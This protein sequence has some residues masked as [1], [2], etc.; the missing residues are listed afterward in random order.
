M[1]TTV[2]NDCSHCRT[3]ECFSL[4][5]GMQEFHRALENSSVPTELGENLRVLKRGLNALY[6]KL[7][8]FYLL[9]HTD[10]SMVDVHLLRES[11]FKPRIKTERYFQDVYY[12]SVVYH[13][14]QLCHVILLQTIYGPKCFH[15]SSNLLLNDYSVTQW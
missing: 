12:T 6:L 1:L 13:R 11:N 5:I 3:A 8:D 9:C 14:I 15:S 2:P 4:G 7:P 10:R